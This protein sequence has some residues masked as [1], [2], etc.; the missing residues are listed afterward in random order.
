MNPRAY[1]IREKALS[2]IMVAVV[3]VFLLQRFVIGPYRTRVNELET[4]KA[5]KERQLRRIRTI[6]SSRKEIEADYARRFNSRTGARPVPGE[7]GTFLKSI[8]KVAREKNVR[9]LDIRP[10]P[11]VDQ[12]GAPTPSAHFVT[13]STWPHLAALLTALEDQRVA[14]EKITLTRSPQSPQEIKAQLHLAQE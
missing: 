8:E 1:S 13:E 5:R 7:M 10:N 12:T 2:A 9:V 11:T 3:S 14:V 4:L 6:L